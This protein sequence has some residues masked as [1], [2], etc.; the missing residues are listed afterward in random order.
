MNENLHPEK[1]S[2]QCPDCMRRAKRNSIDKVIEILKAL[3]NTEIRGFIIALFFS[4]FWAMGGKK[5]IEKYEQI[6]CVDETHAIIIAN[7]KGRGKNLVVWGSGIDLLVKYFNSNSIKFKIYSCY[8]P[9]CFQTALVKSK[10]PN[11]WIFAHGDRHGIS[12]AKDC[13]Y[14]FCLVKST[15][16][17]TFIGQI[18]CCH[19]SGTTLWEYLSDKPGLFSEGFMMFINFVRISKNGLMILKI[20]FCRFFLTGTTQPA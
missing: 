5:C 10:A 14:P 7:H 16:K 20:R 17:R 8:N 11:L 19:N 18:H 13:Y 9:K 4:Y 3:K 12:F 1:S 6:N 15:T 2:Y